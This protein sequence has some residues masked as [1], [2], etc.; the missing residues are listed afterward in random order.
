MQWKEDGLSDESYSGTDSKGSFSQ[1]M[2]LMIMGTLGQHI[3]QW[4]SNFWNSIEKMPLAIGS[5]RQ[6]T[7]FK[8][9]LWLTGRGAK[10]NIIS[11]DEI[12]I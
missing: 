5:K 12:S 7:Q 9:G 2:R 11:D 3:G 1:E 6:V 10:A 4:I 8:I